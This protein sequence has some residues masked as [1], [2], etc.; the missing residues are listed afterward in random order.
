[1]QDLNIADARFAYILKCIGHYYEGNIYFL[2][3]IVSLAFL[4]FFGSRQTGGLRSKE[5]YGRWRELFLPQF[6]V[7]ELRV[8]NPVFPVMLTAF[9]G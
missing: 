2:L 9:S 3:Y 7:M 8:Y 6:I 4:S 5:R 1:M